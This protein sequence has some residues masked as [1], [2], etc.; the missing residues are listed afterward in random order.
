MNNLGIEY[1]VGKKSHLNN[2]LKPFSKEVINFLDEFSRL[3]NSRKNLENYPDIRALAFFCRKRNILNFKDKYYNPKRIRFGLGLVFHVT[4][5]NIPTN[6]MYS[7]IFG[8][9]SGN[10]NIVKVPSRKFDEIKIICEEIEYLLK[11]KKHLIVKQMIKI[12][13]YDSSENQITNNISE[14]VDARLIWGGDKTIK[15]I[16]KIKTKARTIDVPFTDRY[17]IS[18]INSDKLLQ[19][20]DYKF[21]ILLKNFY[22]DTYEVDQNACSSPHIILWKGDKKNYAK[23]KFWNNLNLLVEKNYNPP[24]ISSIDNYCRLSKELIGNN[25]IHSFKIFNKALYVIK[26]KKIYPE[27]FVEKSK[28]GFFYE[29]NIGNLQNIHHLVK[30]KLQTITYFG[31]S[32]KFLEKF[33]SEY[34]FNG[35]DRIVP[36]GQALNINL[37]WD[38]YDLTTKL[39]REIEIR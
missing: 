29:C 18:I 38:G 5:S 4:P 26:L 8:L 3:I 6:F 9:I 22:N 35:I 21:N 15:E 16:R 2:F 23:K 14:I 37:V 12:L 13:R 27:I 17:S 10:A 28:W 25:N 30:K 39:S 31:F 20:P 1:L 19:L 33:F 11:K 24:V 7:L 32:K 36:I 34:N